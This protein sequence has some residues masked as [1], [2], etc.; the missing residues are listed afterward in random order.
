MILR[1]RRLPEEVV[2]HIFEYVYGMPVENKQRLIQ[3]IKSYRERK[4][5]VEDQPMDGE[6]M[7]VRH[8]WRDSGCLCTSSVKKKEK[9][10]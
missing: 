9:N 7:C 10:K 4:H 8:Y 2:C 6:E 5:I 3:Q 1:T